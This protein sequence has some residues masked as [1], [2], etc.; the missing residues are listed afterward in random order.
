MWLVSLSCPSPLG[1][2][3]EA[4]VRVG[5]V[6]ASCLRVA[7]DGGWSAVLHVPSFFGNPPHVLACFF[8]MGGLPHHLPT[9]TPFPSASSLSSV[10]L[11]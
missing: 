4:G 9:Q 11:I 8:P 10:P 2:S 6:L 3:E 1:V 7:L 5:W